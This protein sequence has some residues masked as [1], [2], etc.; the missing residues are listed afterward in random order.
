VL[1]LLESIENGIIATGQSCLLAELALG[2]LSLVLPLLQRSLGKFP[3]GTAG[4]RR[5]HQEV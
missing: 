3:D 1:F 2:R 5:T 4:E